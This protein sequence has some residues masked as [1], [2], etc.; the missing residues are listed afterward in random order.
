MIGDIVGM[1]TVAKTLSSKTHYSL[2]SKD[3]IAGQTL[4]VLERNSY[5]DCLCLIGDHA[6]AD[7]AAED[8]ISF[9]PTRRPWSCVLLAD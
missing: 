4:K 8:I 7:V 6:I 1:A 3:E 5:G 9:V 2:C